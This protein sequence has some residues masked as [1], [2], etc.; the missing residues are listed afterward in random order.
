MHERDVAKEMGWMPSAGVSL[1]DSGLRMLSE[2][3]QVGQFRRCQRGQRMRRAAG[4]NGSTDLIRTDLMKR[5][6]T[7]RAESMTR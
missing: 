1:A 7:R 4:K 5:E 3:M 2:I 6:I